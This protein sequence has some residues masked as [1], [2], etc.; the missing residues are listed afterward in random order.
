VC[1]LEAFQERFLGRELRALVLRERA[2]RGAI[3]GLTGNYI[4]V[5]VSGDDS[6]MNRFVNV[7][8][9]GPGEAGRWKANRATGGGGGLMR[10]VV[11]RIACATVEV[12]GRVV[13]RS[14]G[15]LLVFVG[16]RRG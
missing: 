2:R 8:I 14:D 13:A 5:E 16:V 6:L 10:A 15:G 12:D 11:Q 3:R 1:K 4:E 7:R 9:E